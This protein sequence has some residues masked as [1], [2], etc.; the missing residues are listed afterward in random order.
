LVLAQEQVTKQQEPVL[1][2]LQEQVP[3]PVA[4]PLR[5]EAELVQVQ[6][7]QDALLVQARLVQVGQR[8]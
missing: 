4:L 6:A 7:G 1:T 8:P 2:V 3:G 5:T